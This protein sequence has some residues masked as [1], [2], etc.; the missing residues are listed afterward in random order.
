MGV[1][2][3]LADSV[4]VMYHGK[5][6]ERAPVRELFAN[7]REDYTK[8]LLGAVPRLGTKSLSVITPA[9]ELEAMRETTPVVEADGLEVTYPG[10]LGAPSFTAVKGVSFQI[11][12]G[13]VFGLS[14]IHI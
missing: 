6:I 9:A 5:I 4:A 2:A 7:P 3:D 8:K 10:R 1:V 13:E 14:L 12:K 11:H